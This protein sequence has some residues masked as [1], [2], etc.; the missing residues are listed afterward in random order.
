MKKKFRK[1]LADKCSDFGLTDK[2]LDTLVDLGSA[3]LKDDA[4]DEDIANAVD[5][6][7]PYA[8]AMQAEITRK[9]QNKDPKQS[10]KQS[11]EQEGNGE[12]NNPTAV[13]EW[14]AAY[15]KRL[16]TLEKENSDLKAEKAAT[17]RAQQI[18]DKAKKL[19]I[20]EFLIAG[21]TFAEDAD[22]DKEL[23]DFKQQL[24]NHNLVPKGQAHETV[25]PTAQMQTEEDAW[26][27]SLPDK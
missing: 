5:S 19:G 16:E 26:A 1:A 25:T 2:A 11:D 4:S 18:A 12:G 24:V 20:P 10:A 13:P 7:V 17:T 21:R 3:S 27:K 23:A 15:Q 6:L 9:T 8:K 22:L 14:F